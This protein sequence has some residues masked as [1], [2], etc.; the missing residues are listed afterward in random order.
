MS[1]PFPAVDLSLSLIGSSLGLSTPYKMS[2]LSG[3][4]VYATNG[5]RF[6]INSANLNFGF[7]SGKYTTAPAISPIDISYSTT[8]T[9]S[10]PAGQP[11]TPNRF[12][13]TLYGAGGGGGGGGGGAYGT[14]ENASG[15]G[16]GGGGGG[17]SFTLTFQYTGQIINCTIGFGGNPGGGG[18]GDSGG[19]GQTGGTGD[20]GGDTIIFISGQPSFTAPGGYGGA[21]GAGGVG[22]DGGSKTGGGGGNGGS[23][24]VAGVKGGNG[25]FSFSNTTGGGG[26]TGGNTGNIY[27]YGNGGSGGKGG[28]TRSGS[29]DRGNNG[30]K[31]ND[32]G[33]II[34]W[35]YEN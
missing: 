28:D 10:P 33:I 32:G 4:R 16:G 14:L 30:N 3:K 9:I 21:G 31:G 22:W 13:V 2:D 34:T 27:N 25:Q 12:V 11:R 35:Y 20:P 7:F 17:N 6:I 24:Y 8:G 1:N 19:V 18:N 15:G 26:G 29:Y 23:L 5:A